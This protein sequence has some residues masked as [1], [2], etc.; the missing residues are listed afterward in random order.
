MET[1]LDERRQQKSGA[2]DIKVDAAKEQKII[3]HSKTLKL[4]DEKI[5]KLE[6]TRKQYPGIR[7]ED[8]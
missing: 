5:S 1:A 4:T 2:T 7:E 6:G 3:R 8:R